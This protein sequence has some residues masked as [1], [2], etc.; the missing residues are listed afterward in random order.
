M[1]SDV[2]EAQID[3]LSGAEI[4]NLLRLLFRPE[5]FAGGPG[6]LLWKARFS[7]EVASAR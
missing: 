2:A 5:A 3:D 1:G 7:A 6:N 4:D